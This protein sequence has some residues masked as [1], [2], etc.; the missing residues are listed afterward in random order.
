MAI[1]LV[2]I[3]GIPST[4][5]AI[6]WRLSCAARPAWRATAKR[7]LVC[8]PTGR[9]PGRSERTGGR[10]SISGDE[11]VNGRVTFTLPSPYGAVERHSSG[12]L[13]T[14]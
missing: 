3:L 12:F 1:V 7:A 4:W 14:S 10:A 6:A 13:S 5:T 2:F 9:W 11:R 8:A